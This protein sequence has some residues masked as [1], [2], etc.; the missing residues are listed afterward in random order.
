[1]KVLSYDEVQNNI[2]ALIKF[3]YNKLF[4]WVVQK[5]NYAQLS[6]A[7]STGYSS[8]TSYSSDKSSNSFIGILDI[9]G[10]EILAINSF[11]QLCINFANERCVK[12]LI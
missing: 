2:Y 7:D 9:F 1:M 10:F 11:E 4:S 5:I 8:D 12:T 6:A 3:L